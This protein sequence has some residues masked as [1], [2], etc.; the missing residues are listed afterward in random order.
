MSQQREDRES[1]DKQVVDLGDV[2]DV[3]PMRTRV[4]VKNNAAERAQAPRIG[5]LA[6]GSV[7]GATGATPPAGERTAILPVPTD[8]RTRVGGGTQLGAGIFAA[9][10]EGGT[11]AWKTGELPAPGAH[12]QQYEII[13]QIGA[14]GMGAV[15]LARDQRLGRKVAI[16]LL[17]SPAPELAQRFLIEAKA[18][19][20]C[21][22]ENIVVIYEVGQV[23]ATQ[24]FMVL[25]YLKGGTLTELISDRRKLPPA[26]CLELMVPVARALQCA[27]DQGIVHRDLKPDNIFVTDTGIVKVLDFGIAK[28]FDDVEGAVKLSPEQRAARAAGDTG[29]TVPGTM[30]G[31]MKYMAPEQ[32]G[33]DVEMDERTDVW[34]FGVILFR[35]L[36]GQ[37]PLYPM[38]GHEL[39]VT[40]ILEQPTPRLRDVA[41]QIPKALADIVDRCLMK[42]K[43]ERFASA[44]ELLAALEPFLPGRYAPRALS[45]NE[46]PYAGLAAFQESDA[47]RF[48]GRSSEIAAG[49]ARVRER[50]I[51]AIAGPSGVGKS[52][53]VRA[54]LVP[55][56]KAAG[57]N[58][59][60]HVLR[61][62]RNPMA[63]LAAV[64]ARLM[65]AGQ[66]DAEATT[67]DLAD[68]IED[69]QYQATRLAEQPGH[70]GMVLR[71]RAKRTGR[72]VLLFI[73]QFEELYT[74]V[75]GVHERRAF[76]AALAGAADDADAPIRVVL[77]LRSD[78]LDRVAED[79]AFLADVTA[80]L[81]FLNP[82]GRAG[83]R[84]A[85][86]LPAELAGYRFESAL[87]VDEMLAHLEATPG[88]LPLL[89]FAATKLWEQRDE[90][91]KRLTFAAYQAMGGITGA[92]ATHADAVVTELPPT[93]QTLA[94]AL[95]L[96]LVTPERTRAIVS[97]AELAELSPTAGE[98][99]RL[100][101]HLV[102][103]RLLVVQHTAGAERDAGATIELVHESLITSWPTLRRWLEET[104]EDA[105]FLDQL[106]VAAKQWH[107]RGRPAGLLWRGDA[108][109][110]A[111][112]FAKRGRASVLGEQARAY[113]DAVVA[114]ATRVARR[115]KRMVATIGAVLVLGLIAAGAALWK[116]NGAEAKASQEA[117]AARIAEGNAKQALT[118]AQEKERQRLA[119]ESEKAVAVA[120]KNVIKGDLD[121]AYVDLKAK[122]AQ[123]EIA[124]QTSEAARVAAEAAKLEAEVARDDASRSKNDAVREAA[125]AVEALAKAEAAE[126]LA[127]VEQA[128]AEKLWQAE[129]DRA[130]K[131]EEQLGSAI[132]D[133]LK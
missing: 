40:A 23:G 82:P 79:P 44:S 50:P 129:V 48:F 26:R 125:A 43:D 58:W 11:G 56:L 96:R 99:S 93:S 1:P 49:V 27:H 66:A 5:Q 103:A 32:W 128:R 74:L 101:D 30:M 8:G 76:T 106:R 110:E 7:S 17:Q 116:I 29:L 47:G 15:Y 10:G 126:K 114:E 86:V 13:R 120:D 92:L 6:R 65:K 34:A 102:A 39:I 104:S 91:G 133:T 95:V 83:M 4:G 25:E 98:V 41:P 89:Q 62:G 68:D 57:E 28:V 37:H 122:A 71:Q 36:A 69:Q 119:A 118:E 115:R 123:L 75:P 3:D 21:H 73:D 84:D 94:R 38:D 105:A 31:T 97:V 24:P 22:H 18:T 81:F 63:A 16:K 12:I 72:K 121:Q 45:E 113:L 77:S 132:V 19:A 85:L 9:T 111:Q 88:A 52:S 60:A 55:A 35:M 87:I 61:P 2:A 64:T 53:F 127:Q 90:P 107:G 51:L 131:L 33:I 14:G 100:V 20:R 54:G 109:D 108:A 59:E 117:A 78:F 80:G 130:K 112:R 42:V 67:S 124:F 46:S 70:L